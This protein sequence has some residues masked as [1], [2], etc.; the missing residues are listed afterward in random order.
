MNNV[1]LLHVDDVY[2]DE[3]LHQHSFALVMTEQAMWNTNVF[4][5]GGRRLNDFYT[6]VH[7]TYM[8]SDFVQDTPDMF[9][10]EDT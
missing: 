5:L 6:D 2:G 3:C 1:N 8:Q 10:W 7:E 9:E 4:H